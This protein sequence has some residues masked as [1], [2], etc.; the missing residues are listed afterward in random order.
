MLDSHSVTSDIFSQKQN[1]GTSIDARVK[2]VFILMAVAVN[3]LFMSVWPSI[4][5]AVMCL[6][7]LLSIK[8]PPR[9]LLM[10]LAIP[11]AMAAT[12]AVIQLFLYGTTALFTI[13]GLHL[14]G[15][16]EGLARGLL[17][18]WR[19]IAGSSL[20]LFLS[21]S[22]PTNKLLMAAAWFKTPKILIELAL[23]IYRYIFVLLD[24]VTTMRDA[25][26][27]RLGYHNW[28]QSISSFSTL[29]GGLIL[30]AYDRAERVFDAMLVRGYTGEN[31]IA[32][33][34]RL[35]RKDCLAIAIFV[36]ILV[37]LSFIGALLK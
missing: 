4:G 9:L 2:M 21:M 30:R 31:Q 24:E 5:I 12:V 3:L 11:L 34:E 18:M 6:C 25:Q 13:P 19:V 22:T 29:G 15:Y 20:V 26:R 1:W 16:E 14:T 10:R 27:V 37:S 28:R 35:H 8:V 17:I 33:H 36:V 23:L 7:A 32:Y